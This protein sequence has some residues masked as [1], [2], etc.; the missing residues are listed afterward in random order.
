MTS[1]EARG[2]QIGTPVIQTGGFRGEIIDL[3]DPTY[4]A[5]RVRFEDGPWWAGLWVGVRHLEVD[6]Q[7]DVCEIPL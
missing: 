2:L 4:R 3:Y 6:R 5:L 1:H 7:R